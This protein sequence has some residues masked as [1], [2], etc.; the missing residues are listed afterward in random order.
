MPWIGGPLDDILCEQ[1]ERTVGNDNCVRF[2]GIV[3]ADPG[4][5]SSLPL[6]QGQGAG[7]PLP[8]RRLAVFHG[9]RRL[10]DYNPEGKLLKL[11]VK[12]LPDG[13]P[14]GRRER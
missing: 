10:A 3:P 9:P 1:V 2:D 8:G 11:R 14:G 4:G 5:P 6:R 13:P 7:P 12:R